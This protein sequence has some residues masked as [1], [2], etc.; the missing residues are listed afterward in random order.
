M[1][2]KSKFPDHPL[3]R[4][5]EI[6]HLTIRGLSKITGIPEPS[7][8]AIEQERYRMSRQIAVVLSMVTGVHFQ[9]IYRGENPLRDFFGNP[10]TDK[11]PI[12]PL[13][14]ENDPRV[15]EWMTEEIVA[16]LNK[17]LADLN[18]KLAFIKPILKDAPKLPE[19]L[20]RSS[21]LKAT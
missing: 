21:S 7:I 13:E 19:A 18:L 12:P 17:H 10:L 20:N 14:L 5:R 15:E 11:S 9:S 6:R 2:R 16:S 8:K 3:V 4:L 1:S